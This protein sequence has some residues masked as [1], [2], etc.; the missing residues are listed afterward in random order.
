MINVFFLSEFPITNTDNSQVGWNEREPSL[1]LSIAFT[2]S[3]LLKHLFIVTYLRCLPLVFNCSV[4]NY[5]T[6]T[7]RECFSGFA[8]SPPLEYIEDNVAHKRQ[9]SFAHFI[10]FS[11]LKCQ[12]F[13]CMFFVKYIWI[14][15]KKCFN[16]N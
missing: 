1:F 7:R 2:G 3:R 6:V 12:W 16:K 13:S 5:W 8:K 11:H 15:M 10:K 14:S 9:N 4:S